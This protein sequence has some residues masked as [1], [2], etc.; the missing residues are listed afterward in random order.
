MDMGGFSFADVSESKLL[1]RLQNIFCLVE[2]KFSLG[3]LKSAQHLI[4]PII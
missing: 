4:I 3:E 2:A 1:F